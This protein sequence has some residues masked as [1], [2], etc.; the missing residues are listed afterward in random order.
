MSTW[1]ICTNV[2]VS[3]SFSVS[4]TVHNAITKFRNEEGVSILVAEFLYALNVPV[5]V[6]EAV[7]RNAL[8]VAVI[9]IAGL[10]DLFSRSLGFPKFRGWIWT[11]VNVEKAVFGIDITYQAV[12]KSLFC[13]VVNFFSNKDLET[14]SFS[15]AHLYF[16]IGIS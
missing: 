15:R 13:F 10:A 7:A 9:P 12:N 2:A 14:I 1:T 16:P 8:F 5:S 3:C 4:G 6:L 11:W